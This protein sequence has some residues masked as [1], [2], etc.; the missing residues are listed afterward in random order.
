[1]GMVRKKEK[2]EGTSCGSELME[3]EEIPAEIILEEIMWRLPVKPLA[4]FRSVC[5][6]FNSTI[7]S[8]PKFAILQLKNS[9]AITTTTCFDRKRVMLW[10]CLDCS[11]AFFLEKKNSIF[12]IQKINTSPIKVNKASSSYYSIVASCDGLVC[13]LQQIKNEV[14]SVSNS[15]MFWNPLTGETKRV[16]D[17]PTFPCL[18]KWFT[19]GLG[20]D[21]STD[22]YKLVQINL[23]FEH[24]EIGLFQPNNVGVFSLRANSWRQIQDFPSS[25]LICSFRPGVFNNGALRWTCFSKDNSPN[26]HYKIVSFCLEKEKYTLLDITTIDFRLYNHYHVGIQVLG[27]KLAVYY[28]SNVNC[29]YHLLF[30]NLY[31]NSESWTDHIVT[32]PND[33]W[34]STPLCLFE[35]VGEVLF[36]VSG[37]QLGVYRLKDGA[38]RYLNVLDLPETFQALTFSES[39]ISPN[40][41][42]GTRN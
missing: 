23:G 3:K 35:N 33:T 5:K 30:T 9:S 38:F 37:G 25:N 22:D 19:Y 6:T 42:K 1:M 10:Q 26:Y 16:S 29:S 27:D 20:Y 24:N 39:L 13:L 12:S 36:Q 40:T 28:P 11:S 31:D 15:I 32:I 4:R 21:S 2:R 7:S 14:G 41:Y 18:T 8:D 17:P 34:F